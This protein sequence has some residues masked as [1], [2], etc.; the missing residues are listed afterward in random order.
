MEVKIRLFGNLGSHLPEGGSR[1]FFTRVL[2]EETTIRDLVKELHIPE[3][4]Y[5]IVVVNGMRVTP[6]HR[7][8]DGDE[9]NMFRPT[10]GG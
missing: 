8:R 2:D 1:S 4:I 9:V 7:L 10:G 5:F 3:E 6:E